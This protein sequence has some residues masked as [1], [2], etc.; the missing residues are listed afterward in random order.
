MGMI[1]FSLKSD[2][3]QKLQMQSCYQ[4]MNYP[5]THLPV[6]FQELHHTAMIYNIRHVAGKNIRI[7]W[8]RSKK[9]KRGSCM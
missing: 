7:L 8:R 3:E 5:P 4:H 6:A 2:S 9:K 1:K